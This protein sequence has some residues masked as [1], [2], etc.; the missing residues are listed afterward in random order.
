LPEAWSGFGLGG[1]SFGVKGRL[2][3]RL[4]RWSI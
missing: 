3:R 2:P 4:T 1:K